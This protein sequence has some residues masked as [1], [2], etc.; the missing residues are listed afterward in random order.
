[1][2]GLCECG[3]GTATR[4][5][6]GKPNRFVHG[7]QVRLDK[8]SRN[9]KH[10]LSRSPEANSY[11][12]ARARCTNS[13]KDGWENYG[14]RGI[15]FLFTSVAQLVAEIGRRPEGTTLDRIR[16]DGHYEI[17]NVRWATWH[18]Q[19]VNQRRCNREQTA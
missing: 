10:G 1:M 6:N 4:V 3:C 15:K 9:L 11:K 13:K 17:G 19:R 8:A 14:G 7:H 16:S 5:I 12:S 2:T 18:E